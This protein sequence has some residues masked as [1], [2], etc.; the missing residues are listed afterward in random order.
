MSKFQDYAKTFFNKIVKIEGKTVRLVG[1]CHDDYGNSY[2]GLNE[3]GELHYSDTI[4]RI[5]EVE[6][7][8]D[9]E[10]LFQKAEAFIYYDFREK[11]SVE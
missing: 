10:N 8:S 9:L 6:N 4:S 11:Q 1:F 2:I 3:K 7:P 5:K